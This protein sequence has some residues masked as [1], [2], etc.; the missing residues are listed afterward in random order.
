[1]VKVKK[2]RTKFKWTAEARVT[3]LIA[4][5][6]II[7]PCWF[8]YS[9]FN[10]STKTKVT[11]CGDP[12]GIAVAT[13][14]TNPVD[15]NITSNGG[16]WKITLK[17]PEV[18]APW[19]QVTVNVK[20]GGVPLVQRQITINQPNSV[21]NKNGSKT[22]KWYAYG[23]DGPMN[24]SHDG[25]V[26]ARISPIMD[27]DDFVTLENAY[28]VVVDKDGNGRINPGDLVFLYK[29]YDGDTTPNIGGPGYA[30]IFITNG[31]QIAASNLG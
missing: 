22:A 14:F 27:I 17:S 30:I 12:C 10:P 29:S 5:V 20:T 18:G 21:W 24:Y 23:A 25:A 3:T 2:P 26:K 8:V 28:F 19:N 7:L 31:S 1:M 9:Y 6:I 13:E 15:G 11:G 4:I 16:G